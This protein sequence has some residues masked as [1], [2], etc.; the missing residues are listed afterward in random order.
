MIPTHLYVKR[1][2]VT[3]KCYFGKTT[4]ADPVKYLGSGKVWARHIKKHGIEH[5]ET[6]WHEIFTDQEA[7]TE[8]DCKI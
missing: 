5:V 6:I 1:H 8:F 4:E 2:A 3:G 7:C